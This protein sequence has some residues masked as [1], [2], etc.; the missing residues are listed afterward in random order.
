V[1]RQAKGDLVR[2]KKHIEATG[3]ESGAFRGEIPSGSDR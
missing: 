1:T 3:R 2:F